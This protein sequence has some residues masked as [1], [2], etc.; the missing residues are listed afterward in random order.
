MN[1]QMRRLGAQEG[2]AYNFGRARYGN[3]FNAHRMIHFARTKGLQ[4][5]IEQRLFRAW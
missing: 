2:L 1:H 3:S 5:E 4:T